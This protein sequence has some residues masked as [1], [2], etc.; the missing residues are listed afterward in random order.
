M[1]IM[2]QILLV[3]YQWLVQRNEYTLGSDKIIY[4]FGL[5]F[6]IKKKKLHVFL[7]EIIIF[8]FHVPAKLLVVQF[9][10]N[11]VGTI[12]SSVKLKAFRKINIYFIRPILMYT[13]S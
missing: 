12:F 9:F 11:K 7:N 2:T 13:R 8:F 4:F 10:T 5:V 6:I 1:K 3:V